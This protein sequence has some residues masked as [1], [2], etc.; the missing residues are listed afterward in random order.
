M[1]DLFLSSIAYTIA[2]GFAFFNGA[3]G[4]TYRHA[5]GALFS[6]N[7]A[8]VVNLTATAMWCMWLYTTVDC[9]KCVGMNRFGHLIPLTW[10]HIT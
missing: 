8:A 3:L 2:V 6:P 7:S 9:L 1:C 10:C 4:L 5:W